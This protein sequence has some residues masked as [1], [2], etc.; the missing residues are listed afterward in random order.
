MTPNWDFSKNEYLKLK[1]F[2]VQV[3][4]I[5]NGKS[6]VPLSKIIS[7]K[8][9]KKETA[10]KLARLGYWWKLCGRVKINQELGEEM[11]NPQHQKPQVL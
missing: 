6:S 3:P 4:S 9:K 8:N 10:T 2:E 7:K 5:E 11:E 1:W